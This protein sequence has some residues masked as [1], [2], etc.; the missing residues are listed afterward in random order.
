M[1]NVIF[2]ETKRVTKNLFKQ[3]IPNFE[4]TQNFV[5]CDTCSV[6]DLTS[7]FFKVFLGKLI[8]LCKFEKFLS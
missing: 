2:N 3:V 4:V 7:K 5:N 1:K 6:C 8:E